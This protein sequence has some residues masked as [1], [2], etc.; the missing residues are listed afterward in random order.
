V[1]C[2]HWIGLIESGKRYLPD[3]YY[4]SLL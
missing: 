1:S 2:N 3:C 4:P